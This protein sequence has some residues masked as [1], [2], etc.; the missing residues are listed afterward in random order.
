MQAVLIGEGDNG[1]RVFAHGRRVSKQLVQSGTAVD[2]DMSS[3]GRL[4]EHLGVLESLGA[5]ASC[6]LWVPQDPEDD[7]HVWQRRNLG[8]VDMVDGGG[9]MLARLIEGQDR[10]KFGSRLGKRSEVE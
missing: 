6:L 9:P 3:Q 2:S 10:L 7:G 1:V 5:A 8:I 4:V